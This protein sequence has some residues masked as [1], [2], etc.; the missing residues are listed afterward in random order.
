VKEPPSVNQTSRVGQ[1][2]SFRFYS[3]WGAGI[4]LHGD[5]AIMNRDVAYDV[6]VANGEQ[7]ELNPFED[8][9]NSAKSVTARLRVDLTPRLRLGTSFYH[10]TLESRDFSSI[11]SVGVEGEWTVVGELRMQGEIVVGRMKRRSGLQP[12]NQVGWYI[13]PSFRFP[14]GLTPYFRFERLDL[15]T[16]A[17]ND[18]GGVVLI[19]V[20]YEIARNF[21]LKVE[22]NHFS[23]GSAS[24]YV[25]IPGM[26]YDEI[27]SALVLGF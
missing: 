12:G 25:T 8:D 23:G 5:A 16:K 2:G 6:F 14:I 26:S 4:A 1:R 13:Q 18:S 19:G 7:D 21:H 15:D 10:D 9:D 24:R 17:P 22:N 11:K 20:N 27:K 3:R